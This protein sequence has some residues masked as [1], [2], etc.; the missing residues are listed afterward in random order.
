MMTMEGFT[1]IVNF[2][3]PG[4]GVLM[5]GCEYVLSSINILHIHCYC[6]KEL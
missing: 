4:I 5:L 6:V 3:T 1:K 2:M